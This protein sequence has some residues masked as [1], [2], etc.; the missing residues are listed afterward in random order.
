M[1]RDRVDLQGRLL[2]LVDG[3]RLPIAE[4]GHAV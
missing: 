3:L 2:G 4:L 1:A